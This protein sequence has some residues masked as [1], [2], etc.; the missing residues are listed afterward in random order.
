MYS[1]LVGGP[2]IPLSLAVSA[3]RSQSRDNLVRRLLNA[4]DWPDISSVLERLHRILLV[5]G[6]SIVKTPTPPP[7][8]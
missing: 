6:K 7:N 1:N 3:S 5:S 2:W 8:T 4:F